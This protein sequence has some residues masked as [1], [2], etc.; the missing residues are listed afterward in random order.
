MAALERDLRCKVARAETAVGGGSI[1]RAVRVNTSAGALFV[2]F[3]DTSVAPQLEAECDGVAALAKANAVRTPQVLATGTTHAHAYAAFEWIDFSA[4]TEASEARLGER[5]A[6]LHRVVGKRFGWCRDNY[7][8]AT[9]QLNSEC[10]DW[11]EFWRERRLRYQLQLARKSGAS[12]QLLELGER[13]LPQ[14]GD[15][16]TGYTPVPSLI[17]GDLWS[18]NR[19]ADRAGEPVIFDPAVY[20]ADREA[21]LAMARLFGGFSRSFYV[22]YEREWPLAPGAERRLPLYQLY[23]V[24]NHFNLFGGG[25]HAQAERLLLRLLAEVRA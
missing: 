7:I 10:D 12:A 11:I 9:P 15:F 3:G 18:G 13:L 19:A 17:H 22:A 4:T 8:G 2:K 20:Y 21:E 1:H 25:Y 6:R 16:F 23:H 24:L 5:L 14:L